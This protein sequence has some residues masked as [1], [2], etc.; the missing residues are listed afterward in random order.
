[1]RTVLVVTTDVKHRALYESG[2]EGY[3][4]M[5]F[6]AEGDGGEGTV[7]AFIYDVTGPFDEV[8]RLWLEG[9]EVPVVVLTAEEGIPLPHSP[10]RRVLKHPASLDDIFRALQRLG[11]ADDVAVTR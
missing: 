1:M 6:S 10:R 2:L 7:D 5:R 8:D 11:V 4:R 3:F 9:T